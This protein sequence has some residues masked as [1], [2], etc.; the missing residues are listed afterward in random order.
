MNGGE[1]EGVP[2]I[3]V[4]VH[5]DAEA[6]S[7]CNVYAL[8]KGF[9]IRKGHVRRDSSNNIRQ[10]DFVCSKEGFQRDE[11]LCEV[12]N[13]NRIDRRTG[14][15]ALIRFNVKDGIWT[16]SHINYNHNHELAKP[17]E[18]DLLRSCRKISHVL[19]GMRSSK[20]NVAKHATRRLARHYALPGFK[21]QLDKCFHWCY[22]EAEFEVSWV[23]MMKKF[24]LEDHL[25]LRKLYSLREKWCSAFNLN[26]FSA[27]IESTQRI[28]NTKHFFYKISAK[29]MDLIDFL[30]HYEK[31]TKRMRLVELEEDY[32]CKYDVL[33]LKVNSGIL[34]HGVNVYTNRMFSFFEEELMSCMGVR[35]KEVSNDGELHIY[36]AIEEG[37]G[38]VYKVQFSSLTSDV[39]CCCKLFE[40]MGMLCCHALKAFDVNNLTSIPVQYLLKRWTKDAKNGISVSC[41]I[42][43]SSGDE[44]S[45]QSL[46]LSKLMHEGNNIYSIASLSDSGTKIVKDK[47]AEAMRLLEK[48]RETINMLKNLRKVDEQPSDESEL[49]TDKAKG[50]TNARLKSNSGK[51]KRKMTKGQCNQEMDNLNESVGNSSFGITITLQGN[52][53][54]PHLSQKR[55][56][57]TKA[58]GSSGIGV[59][60]RGEDVAKCQVRTLLAT[61]LGQEAVSTLE[62]E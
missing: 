47:L 22:S 40:S 29:T 21:E 23:D 45:L 34:T 26:F 42:S 31:K 33:L 49:P 56:N 30:H 32:H 53:Q 14:C 59:P 6:Y 50:Q 15:K 1:D 55:M 39:T 60:L 12:K 18:R 16:I 28:E 58:S 35:M 7:L 62:P 4:Q 5:S 24:N 48:D 13:I 9:S 46:R 27:N 54:I 44:K 43:I 25:W 3:G 41:D 51:R 10:R 17:E 38:R 61:H 37:Q 36:E 52:D 8:R 20:V 2:K 11:D 57:L 19:G